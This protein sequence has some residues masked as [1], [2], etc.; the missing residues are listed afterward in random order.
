MSISV[1]RERF[2]S[3]EV[4]AGRAAL[5]EAL[6]GGLDASEVERAGR[7]LLKHPVPGPRVRVLGAC[8]TAWIPPVLTAVAW[9][10]GQ[11][12]A[13]TDG[14]YDNVLQD[15]ERG[16]APEVLVLLP[17]TQRLFSGDVASEIAYWESAWA[18][19]RGA[20]IVQVGFDWTS[21]GPGGVSLSR[22]VSLVRE[23]DRLLRERM[24]VGAAW[25]DLEQISGDVGRAR[26]YES[27]RYHWTKQPFSDDGLVELCRHLHAA[28]R[29]VITGP[30]KLLVLDLDN[31]LW[32][33]VVGETGPHGIAIRETPDGEA[34]RA[35]QAHVGG[36]TQAGTLLAVCSKNNRADALEP[37]EKNG[38]MVLRLEHFATFEA[39]WDS[40]PVAIRRIAE[41]LRLGLDSFVF[42]DD[43]PA[44]REA[45]RQALPEVEVVDVP[46]DPAGY[47]RA[48]EQGLWFERVSL[49]AEDAVRVE[50]YRVEA[51]RRAD[52]ASYG[53][54][55]AYLASLR[56]VADTRR[57]DEADLERVVQLLGKTNQ[58][59]LTT[60]RHGTEVVRGWMDDPRAIPLTIRLADRFGDH[61][62]VAVVLAIP[63]GNSLHIDT[64]LMSCRVIG[65]TLEEFTLARVVE[66]AQA[67]GYRRLTGEYLPTAKNEQVAGL[68][69][70]LG[71]ACVEETAGGARRYAAELAEL[72]LG[73]GFIA[74]SPAGS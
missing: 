6:R 26:F 57:V 20:K 58:F 47:V 60:R 28:V 70:R 41:T 68:Y 67:L 45:V 33:G 31:T 22:E 18:R 51:E 2:K 50:Q 71:F 13:V 35:F 14:E 38:D 66:A 9:A 55:E 46:E 24:P 62:L 48:L 37:F 21:A 34:Y 30:K 17:W 7:L 5:R 16:D 72:S 36:L 39:S 27:R 54:T 23:A 69:D 64:W 3:G 56:M 73:E 61:G 10:R 43:N 44:E 49:T 15:L 40:K 4:E 59:N 53:S 25:V 8:T 12:W 29:A 52:E 65:R 19:A 74:R 42:F 63:E 32:G 11:A 1:A